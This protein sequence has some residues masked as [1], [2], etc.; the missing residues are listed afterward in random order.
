MSFRVRMLLN[1]AAMLTGV[2]L[3]HILKVYGVL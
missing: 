3:G 1:V 2:L